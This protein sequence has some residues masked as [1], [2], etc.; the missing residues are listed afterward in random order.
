LSSPHLPLYDPALSNT[1]ANSMRKILAV[2]LVVCTYTVHAETKTVIN[3]AGTGWG[4]SGNWHPSGVPAD[5]DEVIIPFGQ[6]ISVKG[7]FYNG[8]ANLIIKVYGTLD[9]DPSGK[10]DLGP[11]SQAHLLTSQ[12]SITTNGTSSELIIISGRTKYNGSIDGTVTGPKYAYNSTAISPNGFSAG[13]LPVQIISFTAKGE[14]EQII[15]KWATA[16]ETGTKE[17]IIEKSTNA[18]NWLPLHAVKAKGAPSTYTYIDQ[19]APTKT[20]YYR[21]KSIDVDNSYY[22]STIAKASQ[23]TAD[24]RVGPNPASGYLIIYPGQNQ[25]G[26][27]AAEIM[28]SKGQLLKRIPIRESGSGQIKITLEG[29]AK[30]NYHIT[31]WNG[32]QS[33][34][35]RNLVIQ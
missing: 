10:L 34:S 26:I 4:N 20:T 30:G 3:N 27:T 7:G 16:E 15:L 24:I 18:K 12:A 21:L 19:S 23:Q 1:K 5:G 31:F 9:F 8:S 11:N 32:N 17:F 13:V 6:T 14:N 28:D 2:L 33:L 25:R 29:L 22:Y 35:T